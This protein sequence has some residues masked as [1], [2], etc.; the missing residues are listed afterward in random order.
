MR[1]YKYAPVAVAIVNACQHDVHH[2]HSFAGLKERLLTKREERPTFPPVLD[3]SESV[4]VNSFENTDLDTYSYY[5][6]HGLHVAETNL[7]MAQWTADRFAE[8]GFTASLAKYCMPMLNMD[9]DLKAHV[10][11]YIPKLPSVQVSY[12]A[13]P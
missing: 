13:L 1:L 9:H 6:T 7:S 11:R 4:L 3:E 12:P 8:H 2:L 5:Y 10:S